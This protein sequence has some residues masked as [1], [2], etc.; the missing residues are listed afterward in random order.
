VFTK[1]LIGEVGMVGCV[2]AAFGLRLRVVGIDLSGA[3]LL[4][5]FLIGEASI[6]GIASVP[7]TTEDPASV[8]ADDGTEG[9]I[10]GMCRGVWS[11]W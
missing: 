3:T 1:S 11:P 8:V 9:R 7:T 4:G 5:I 10:R 6:S 2:I